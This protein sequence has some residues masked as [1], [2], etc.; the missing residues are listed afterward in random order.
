[1]LLEEEASGFCVPKVLFERA[2][3]THRNPTAQ[4]VTDAFADTWLSHYPKPVR[5]KTDPEGAFQSTECREYLASNDIRYDPTAGD[6]HFQLGRVERAIQTIKRIGAKLS[7]EFPD[8][9]GIQ[10]LAAAC[11]AH[12]DLRRIKGYSPNQWIFGHAK[13]GWNDVFTR[14]GESYERLMDLRISAQTMFLKHRAHEQLQS[15]LRART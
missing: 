9:S 8:A 15:A 1:M 6:A 5:V 10:I 12:N 4:E 14:Q 2:N 7:T 11:S 13:P 3:G